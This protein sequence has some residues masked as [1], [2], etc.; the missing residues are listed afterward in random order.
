V[1]SIPTSRADIGDASAVRWLT[2]A[3]VV[4]AEN[5]WLFCAA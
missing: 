2:D 5:D 3:V 4:D 1:Q